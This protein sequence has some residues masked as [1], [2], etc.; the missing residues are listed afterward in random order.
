M[1][2]PPEGPSGSWAMG[3]ELVHNGRAVPGN[4]VGIPPACAGKPQGQ[5]NRCMDAQGYRVR[6]T[7]QPAGRYWTFQWI[8]F[9]V[10]A[11]LSVVLVGVAI[12][13]LRRRDV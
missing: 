4:V 6:L 5:L 3:N 10:F 2:V 9:G 8:E 7:Y 1:S 12:V 13:L 11:A